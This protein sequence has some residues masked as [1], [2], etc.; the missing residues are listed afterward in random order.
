MKTKTINDLCLSDHL[1]QERADRM[2]EILS[3]VGIGTVKWIVP[4]TKNPDVVYRFSTTGIIFVCSKSNDMVMTAYLVNKSKAYAVFNGKPPK[5]LWKKILENEK[6]GLTHDQGYVIIALERNKRKE[7]IIMIAVLDWCDGFGNDTCMLG[8]YE[9][10]EIA[11]DKVAPYGENDKFHERRYQEFNLNE[12]VCFDYY[13][14]EP[15]HKKKK[16]KRG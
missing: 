15:L 12:E 1:R 14:A 9:S 8:I 5:E 10:V 13:E 7:L 6:K 3:T 4:S 2:V 11:R 16:K